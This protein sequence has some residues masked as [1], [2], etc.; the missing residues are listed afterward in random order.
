M[1]KKEYQLGCKLGTATHRLRKL[2]LFDLVVKLDLHV[3]YRCGKMIEGVEELSLDHKTPWL[4]S[5]N[6]KKLFFDLDNIGFSHVRCN[7]NARRKFWRKTA[8]NSGFKGVYY[9]PVRHDKPYKVCLEVDGVTK[10][11]GRFQDSKEAA[12]FYDQKSKEFLG[13][14]AITNLELGLLSG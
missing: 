12:L 3:C 7:T 13:A 2:V 9:D 11:L 8:S 14:S 4:D 6:P 10:T 1:N 5:K